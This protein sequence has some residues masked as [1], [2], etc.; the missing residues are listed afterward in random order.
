[1]ATTSYV[2]K[3]G[4]RRY[5]GI[6]IHRAQRTNFS[7]LKHSCQL[8]ALVGRE[9]DILTLTVIDAPVKIPAVSNSLFTS[10]ATSLSSREEY[11]ASNDWS[12]F[13]NMW[14]LIRESTEICDAP[15]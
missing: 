13:V 11:T 5:F 1:M 4:E 9:L 8:V 7:I 6:S 15:W 3:R 14:T 2:E 12:H 10:I